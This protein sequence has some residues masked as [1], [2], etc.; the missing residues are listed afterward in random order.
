MSEPFCDFVQW[1]FEQSGI[2]SL[3][4][5]A[6]GDFSCNGR[7]SRSN[8]LLCRNPRMDGVGM[9]VGNRYYRRLVSEDR[10]V[11][12]LLDCYSG[13]LQAFPVYPLPTK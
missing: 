7:Y 5:I 8:I 9:P 12:E 3:Q 11:W 13:A 4:I 1:A 6:F 2:Q 10:A